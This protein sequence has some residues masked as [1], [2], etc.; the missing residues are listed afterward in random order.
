MRSQNHS[1]GWFKRLLSKQIFL[2]YV[3]GECLE[4]LADVFS[5]VGSL[6]SDLS[7]VQVASLP[8]RREVT[9]EALA[10]L[11]LKNLRL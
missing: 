3:V 9:A 10:G 11:W 2:D 1:G 5:L 8:Q 7:S 6:P 4:I